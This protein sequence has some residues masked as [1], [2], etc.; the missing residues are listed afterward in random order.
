MFRRLNPCLDVKP[1][2]IFNCLK[3]LRPYHGILLLYEQNELLGINNI[4]Q[5]VPYVYI[6]KKVIAMFLTKLQNEHM[7]WSRTDSKCFSCEKHHV[8]TFV[9]IHMEHPVVCFG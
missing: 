2:A 7:V 8:F 9:S 5:G 4:V 6:Q 1:E 3:A